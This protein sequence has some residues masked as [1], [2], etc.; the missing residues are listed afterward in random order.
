MKMNKAPLLR[1]GVLIG[2]L[3]ALSGQAAPVA[4]PQVSP[5]DWLLTQVRIGESTNKYEL[6]QQSLYRL[7]KIDPDNPQVLAA[8]LRLALHQGDLTAAQTL[9]DQLNRQAPGSA[10]ARESAAGL[11]MMSPDGRQQLQQA[12]LLATSGRLAEAKDAYDALFSGV[13]PDPN[14]ALEYWRLL[15]RLPGQ[16]DRAWQQLQQLEQRYPGNVGVGLQIARMA[17]DRQQPELATAQLKRLAESS[18]GRDA[19]ADLWLQHI[20]DQ[21]IS[22]SSVAQLKAYLAVFTDGDA[23]QQGM[24]ALSRQQKTL[25]DPAYRERMRALALVEAGNVNQA[26]STLNRAL[27]ANPDDAELMGAMGQTQARAGHRA[28]AILWLERAIKAGQQSTLVGKW[29]SLLQTNRYWLA[30]EQGDKALAQ[31]DIKSAEQHYR[32]AQTFDSSDSYALIGLGD[33]AMA[34]NNS[35]GAE[36]LWQRAR[37]LDGSNITA[38]RRLAAL[39]QAVSPAR[40]MAFINSLPA[41]QQRALADTLRAL[42]SDSL[43]AEADTLAQQARWPQ[44]VEKYREALALAPDDVWLSYRLAGALRNR[45]DVQQANAVMRAVAQQHPQDPTALY[46]TALWFSGNDDERTALATLQRLPGSQWSGDMRQLA[47]RLKQNQIFAQADRLRAAGNEQAAIALLE[48]Q[49]VSGRRD[50][51]LADWA[52]ARGDA[53]QALTGY[54]QVLSRQP[55]DGD[56]ALGRIEALVALQRNAEARQALAQLRPAAPGLNVAR[57]VALAWQAVGETARAAE[58]FAGLK[59]RAASLPPSQAKALLFRD[60]ARLERAQQQPEQALADYREAMT[61]SGIN[62]GG[63][64]SRA[65]RNDPRD[66]W[67]ERGLR[68]DTADLYRQQQTTLTLQQDYSRNSGTGGI[69]DFTAHTTMLQAERPLADGRGF[70][71]VDRVELSAGTFAT[72]NGSIDERFGS[73]DDASSGGCRGPTHQRDSGTAL[74][75]GWHNGV[76]SADLGT[77]PLGFEVTNWTGGLSW[78]TDIRDLGVTLTASRRP[79]TSSLLAYAGTRDLAASG[80]KRWGGVVATGGSI[81]LSYDQGGAHGVWGDISAHQ[82]SGKNVADNSRERLMGGY[83]YKLI[84]SDNRRATVGLNTMLWHYQK[85]L[86][87]YTFGQGG[88]Y[89]PQQYLSFSV[90]V[91]WRQRT[92]NWSFDLGGSLSWSH[93][94]THAQQRYPVNPGFALASN[95]SS[96]SSIGGGVGYTLQAV[97]ERRLTSDWFIGAGVDIQQA[98]DYTPSHGLIYVRYAAGGWEGDLDMPPQPLIPYADSK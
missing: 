47:E 36:Q 86:S 61:A 79:I 80:G 62:S 18:G 3:G 90:P 73:C 94:A 82:I 32:T 38:V 6:V 63:N 49:P 26:M 91:T 28:V 30:I 78:K 15:A 46:A 34:R 29:Q 77:T 76:W 20:N 51:T 50:L 71:R 31:H 83:Y 4:G 74:G 9:L 33:V 69:S 88:Y 68:S 8:R 66:T 55:E 41:A 24:E 17:F 22:D 60:A 23:H 37:Q 11:R 93:S 98:K 5:V 39:Y 14:I 58:L 16:Q 1:A 52:L 44:A 96:A 40:E 43:R 72:R 10:A 84:N 67:L 75:A 56:A 53:Q 87:D 95:P 54:Q 81:G 45:G 97:V 57:R 7:E 48:Q 35:A 65:T 89:S 12:R 27:K 92:E 70:L 59:Q 42:R 64:L 13:F 85:D 19:A 25:A 2:V 21:T